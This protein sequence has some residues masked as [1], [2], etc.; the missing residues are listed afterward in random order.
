[1]NF[2]KKCE[3]AELA[4]AEILREPG[5]RMRHVYFPLSGFISLMMK[6]EKELACKWASSATKACSA[7]RASWA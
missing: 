1:M 4:F 3:G 7:Q 6:L 2:P 5:E